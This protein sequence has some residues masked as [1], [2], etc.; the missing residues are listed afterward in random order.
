MAAGAFAT[1][2]SLFK[3]IQGFQDGGI[4]GGN[5]FSGDRT[6]ILANAGER[7]LNI[8]Q[9]EFVVG[10]QRRLAE[11]MA[12]MS[13]NQQELLEALQENQDGGEIKLTTSLV[14]SDYV[15]IVDK[16]VQ[17]Q[18]FTRLTGG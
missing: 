1:V 4:I 3:N 14:A 12:M 6:P 15:D 18:S 8:P 9:Q 5:S 7:V 11:Q 2:D 17:E 13:K 10:S 16:G